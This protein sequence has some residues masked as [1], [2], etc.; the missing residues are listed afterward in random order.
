M[1]YISTVS[2]ETG[3]GTVFFRHVP[4]SLFGDTEL[5]YAQLQTHSYYEL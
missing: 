2:E 1:C 4:L 3:R 5:L